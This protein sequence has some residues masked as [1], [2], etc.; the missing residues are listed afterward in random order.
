MG[1]RVDPRLAAEVAGYGADTINKCFNCGNYTAVCSLSKD[2]TVFPRRM[3]RYLQLGLRD[4]LVEAPEP[5]LCYY[6]GTCSDTC[7]RE[8]FPGELMMATR[9][10]LTA[11]YDFTGLSRK[12]YLS[13]AWEIGLLAAGALLVLALFVVP[14]WLGIP[15]GF[16]DLPVAAREHVRVAIFANTE[17]VHIGDWVLAVVLGLLLWTNA[18]R[19][20]YFVVRGEKGV[21]IPFTLWFT[22]FYQMVVHGLTQRRWL[23]CDNDTRLKW[24]QHFLLVTGYGTMLLLVV[25]LLPIFQVD[26]A[27]FHWTS[28]P[29]YYATL[30]L[31]A[32]TLLAIRG[33]LEKKEPIHRFSHPTDWMFLILLLL[34]A[35]S[36]IV[37]NIFRLMDLAWP[38]YIAYVVH[39]MIAVPMLIVEVPFGKWA[40]LIFRP[41]SKY[42]V[43]VLEAA[44]ERQTV[45]AGVPKPATV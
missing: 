37:V 26:R 15:F 7:P 5:W 33:R 43:A 28:I 41:V 12:L 8:A 44:R 36:G 22:K 25:L 38:T 30:M 40:H 14:G 27:E 32:V 2:D 13:K 35:L 18:F 24:L 6:C 4:K 31:L 9:R 45:R 23:E 21:R 19:M 20:I 16:R 3:I 42:I 29:G 11:Q 10:W 34:T 39:L 1:S 17:W